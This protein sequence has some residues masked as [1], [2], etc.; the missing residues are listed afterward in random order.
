[1]RHGVVFNLTPD[2]ALESD[3]CS[4]NLIISRQKKK[5]YL[6]KNF[7]PYYILQTTVRRNL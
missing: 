7:V 2:R 6:S 4:I 1:M 3:A 5:K